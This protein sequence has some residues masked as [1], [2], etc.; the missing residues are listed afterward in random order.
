MKEEP[1]GRNG[2]VPKGIEKGV[3]VKVMNHLI[4]GGFQLNQLSHRRIQVLSSQPQLSPPCL[5]FETCGSDLHCQGNMKIALT[6]PRGKDI[7]F[8]FAFKTHSG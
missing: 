3:C 2:D 6:F 8:I 7:R 1:C 5:K 4:G